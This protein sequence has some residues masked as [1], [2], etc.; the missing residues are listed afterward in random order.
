MTHAMAD[1]IRIRTFSKTASYE[2]WYGKL[3]GADFVP[4]HK[5]ARYSYRNEPE[6][7]SYKEGE[8]I[9]D[10]EGVSAPDPETTDFVVVEAVPNFDNLVSMAIHVIDGTEQVGDVIN[11]YNLISENA[12]YT[13]EIATRPELFDGTI[14]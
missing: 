2:M 6:Q 4:M 12:I 14:F 10:A 13:H 5:V 11:A 7:V 8:I 9:V 1:D 3:D